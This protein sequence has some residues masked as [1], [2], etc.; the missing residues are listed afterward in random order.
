[1]KTTGDEKKSCQ[2]SG[3]I[4]QRD[5]FKMEAWLLVTELKIKSQGDNAKSSI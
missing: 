5:S 2:K 1:M 4:L 3:W